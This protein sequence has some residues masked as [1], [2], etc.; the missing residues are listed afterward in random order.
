[1]D[2]TRNTRRKSLP[3]RK[4]RYTLQ[5]ERETWYIKNRVIYVNFENYDVEMI[6]GKT[7]RSVNLCVRNCITPLFEK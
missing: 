7:K 6:R 1:M 3:R 5:K 2:E 4:T